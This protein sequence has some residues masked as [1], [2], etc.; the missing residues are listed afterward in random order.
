MTTACLG[1][2]QSQPTHQSA[3]AVI[4]GEEPAILQRIADP[5]IAAA[6]WQRT[7]DQRFQT[8]INALPDDHLPDLRIQSHVAHVQVS[9]LEACRDK[10][11][12]VGPDLTMLSADAAALAGQFARIM[13]VDDLLIRFDVSDDVM[14]PRFHQDNVSARLLCTYRGLGTEFV[15][16]DAID[17]NSEDPNVIGRMTTGAVGVFRGKKW[18]SEETCALMHRSPSLEPGLGARMLLVIDA[19]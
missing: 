9:L 12:E 5:G 19:A 1:R 7:L 10:G 15:S 3:T 6:I 18:P 4:F 13:V 11:L 17:K 16:K 14:C 8:W 2:S